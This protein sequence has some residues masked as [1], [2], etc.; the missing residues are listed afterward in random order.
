MARQKAM[1]RSRPQAATRTRRQAPRIQMLDVEAAQV[2]GKAL[3]LAPEL[4]TLNVFR[5]LL[6]QEPVAQAIAGTLLTL[7]RTGNRLDVRV[8]E[9]IIMRIGWVTGS[10]YEWTQHWRV[11][12]GL[13]IPAADLVGVRDWPAAK[14]FSA[15]ERAALAATDE[16]LGDGHISR[17][18]WS[19]LARHLAAD[20]LVE[21]VIAIG[22]WSM[23][24]Q[25]L[26][27]LDVQLEEGVVPWPPDGKVPA[28]RSSG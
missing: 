18:T 2:R 28:A 4:A 7:L 6:H 14:C 10:C 22:N 27:S 1:P 26:Q 9:L 20:T 19:R 25:L 23:F 24:A 12:R 8:R 17:R 16:T 13:D 15:L 5:T 21:L 11:A 3:G